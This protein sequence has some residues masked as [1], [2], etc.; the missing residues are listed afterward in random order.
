MKTGCC[1]DR[2]HRIGIWLVR[3]ED[4]VK[5]NE[6]PV[7]NR[8]WKLGG[9]MRSQNEN[10]PGG[11]RTTQSLDPCRGEEVPGPSCMGPTP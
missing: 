7:Q 9:E 6:I 5:G 11:I 2:I 8:S 10:G 3:C 1:S 4:R